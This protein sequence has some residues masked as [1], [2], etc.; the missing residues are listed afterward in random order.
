MLTATIHLDLDRD[1]VLS[2]LNSV[3]NGPF[4]VPFYNI[5][6]SDRVKFV[7]NTGKHRDE[8]AAILHESD[9][10]EMI[11]YASESQLLV[12]KRSS[13]A[14]PVIRENNGILY[15]M[16]QFDGTRRVF[17]IIISERDDLKAII[18]DLR[19]LGSIRLE[20]LESFAASSSSLLSS[21][22][23]E[24]IKHAYEAGYFDWPR[25]ADAETLANQL[26]ISHSTF[27]E[28]LRKA[29]KKVISEALSGA[30]L[31]EQTSPESI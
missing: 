10:I 5:V 29:E 25:R 28:H 4:A 17:D 1:F 11:E 13:G 7:I 22:Q 23:L 3:C 20:R 27:L 6:D 31:A 12:T 2:D 9:A 14:L 19:T 26:D 16:S 18:N 30:T 21:R 24:T 8:C 15:N